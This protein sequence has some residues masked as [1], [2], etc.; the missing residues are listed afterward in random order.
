MKNM[1]KG[2]FASRGYTLIEVLVGILIFAV[3]MM[4]LAQLQG[5]LAQN[6]GD[7]NART[8]AMNVAE[9]VIEEAR[10]FTTD[11]AKYAYSD[12]VGGTRTI[13]KSG[14][15]FLVNTVESSSLEP[16]ISVSVNWTTGL[17][18]IR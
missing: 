15:Q 11:G 9:S 14:A 16:P 5:N 8:V 17:T 1:D 10:S 12:I 6:S 2:I 7:A 13:E 3:G 18:T 4:A